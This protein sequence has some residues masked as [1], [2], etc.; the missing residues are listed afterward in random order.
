MKLHQIHLGRKS[1]VLSL[2]LLIS[3]FLS[4]CSNSDIQN[5]QQQL[6]Q[7][8]LAKP[9]DKP[10]DKE[11]PKAWGEVNFTHLVPVDIDTAAARLKR[12]YNFT[13]DSEI[14]AARNGGK[15]NAGWVASAMA[16]GTEW[17]AQPGAHYR[18]SRNWAVKDRLI[19]ELT[20]SGNHTIISGIYRSQDEK[21]LEVN[22]TK[23]LIN[24]VQL[25]ALNNQEK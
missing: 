12:Y 8:G 14:V 18:M 25:V 24:Q 9:V 1:W 2:S 13:S 21:H 5:V 23:N 22:W 7:F 15:G 10:A 6:S 20:R 3:V 16:E 17:D 11:T 19:L 4:G